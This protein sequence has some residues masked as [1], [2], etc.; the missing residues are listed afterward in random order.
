MD[1]GADPM[2]ILVWLRIT[3]RLHIRNSLTKS[4][5]TGAK[6]F[7]KIDTHIRQKRAN[8]Y[9]KKEGRA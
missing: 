3:T 1:M 6:S 9:K 2:R 5:T 4:N 8:F 7:A